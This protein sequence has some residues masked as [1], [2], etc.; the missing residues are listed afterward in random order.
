[1]TINIIYAKIIITS[2]ESRKKEGRVIKKEYR[3][4]ELLNIAYKLFSTKGYEN[5]SIDE[6]IEQA[7]IAKGTYYYYFKSKEETLE[8]VIE[9]MISQE[10]E[11]AKAVLKSNL[12]VQEKLLGIILSMRPNTDE[13]KLQ[14]TINKPENI[15]M[16]EKINAKL[17]KYITPLIA[18]VIEEGNNNGIFDCNN[19]KERVEIILIIVNNLFD[20]TTKMQENSKTYIE[21]FI[22]LVEKILGAK[23][24][25]MDFA[26]RLIN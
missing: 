7:C 6:I 19:I 8:R 20:D 23:K 4:K 5:T 16:H 24:S 18:D 9:M 11:K 1:M 22:D 25:T 2:T 15:I 12:S 17:I 3:E 13:T 14:D 10:L 21:V 26:K